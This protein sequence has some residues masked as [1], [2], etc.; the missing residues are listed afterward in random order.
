MVAEADESDRSFLRLYPTLAVV[1]N[2]DLEHLDTYT[3][4]DDIKRTFTQFLSNVPFYGKAIVL[5]RSCPHI[6]A[7]LPSLAHIK[8]IKYGLALSDN[9]DHHADIYAKEIVLEKDHSECMV[10]SKQQ[11]EPL[12]QLV[13]AMPGKHNLLNALA[14][15][16]TTLDVGVSFQCCRSI[17]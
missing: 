6:R 1:T 16:A 12:G 4:I 7:I 2:I 17:A 14:A 3:D 15:I 10:Y 5:H 13:L 9:E 11:A 8:M